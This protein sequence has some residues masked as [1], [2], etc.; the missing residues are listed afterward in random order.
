MGKTL[1]IIVRIL[2]FHLDLDLII[3]VTVVQVCKIKILG[4]LDGGPP[5][6]PFDLKKCQ[7]PLSLF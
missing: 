5:M 6:S 2:L 1:S 3:C 7:C 4:A